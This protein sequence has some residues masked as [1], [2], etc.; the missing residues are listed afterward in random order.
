MRNLG[1]GGFSDSFPC[2]GF[3]WFIWRVVR[4]SEAKQHGFY[5][6]KQADM[7]NVRV[8][9]VVC[10]LCYR[11]ED[12]GE[13]L[14]AIGRWVGRGGGFLWLNGNRLVLQCLFYHTGDVENDRF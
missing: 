9:V 10:G 14:N 5:V 3:V 8:R 13:G 2:L 12:A 1:P 6:L 11:G 7:I 4:P